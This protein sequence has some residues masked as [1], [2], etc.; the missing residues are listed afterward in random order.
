MK[1]LS[2][3][4]QREQLRNRR[5]PLHP[6]LAATMIKTS[7]GRYALDHPLVREVEVDPDRAAHLNKHYEMKLNEARD[8][9]EKG[10]W[11]TYIMV[12]EK[13]HSTG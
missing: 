2:L 13:P 12:H 9:F 6:D 7:A 1:S 8:A 4:K 5:E 10:D 11:H 3:I